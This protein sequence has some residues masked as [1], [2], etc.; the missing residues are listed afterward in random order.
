MIWSKKY[1]FVFIHNNKAAGTSIEHIFRN[2]K[3]Y[4]A[5]F[6]KAYNVAWKCRDELLG[7]EQWNGHFTFM[8]V[9]N[10]WSKMVSLY[11]D[12]RKLNFLPKSLQ[13]NDFMKIIDTCR[14]DEKFSTFKHPYETRNQLGRCTDKGGS[15]I[16]DFIGRMENLKSDWQKVCKKI[17]IKES[18]P[19]LKKRKKSKPWKDY[20]NKKSIEIVSERFAKDIEHFGYTF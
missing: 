9:R 5:F 4:D 16:V 3:K 11:E 2:K 15:V 8:I 7:T 1:G 20:Y 13:F 6:S 14:S 19:R 12:W 18:L 17:G 10:P